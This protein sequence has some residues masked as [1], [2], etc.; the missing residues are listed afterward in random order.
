MD[1]IAGE[2]EDRDF[3]IVVLSKDN[4]RSPWINF[5]AGALGKSLGVGKVAPLLLDVTRADV[6]G[7]IAQ[8]Q[9]TL[10][11]ERDDVRQFVRDLGAL[12]A[13]VP[14]ESIDALFG[15]KWSELEEVI[16]EASGIQNP[17]TTRSTASM[18][19][20]V[21]EHV[22]AIRSTGRLALSQEE[23]SLRQERLALLDKRHGGRVFGTGPGVH[24]DVLD[25]DPKGDQ[26]LV[27][28]SSSEARDWIAASSGEFTPF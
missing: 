15:V 8:F 18:L 24:V 20:E 22:R 14:Q 3:G 28:I 10:L 17:K 4:M 5:E 2:L 26:V 11:S 9:S 1:V 27:Q 23:E 25:Y 12:T 16:D 19:E 7:P 13:G 6:E 21:L